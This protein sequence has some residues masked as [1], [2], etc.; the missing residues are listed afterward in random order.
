MIII[1]IATAQYIAFKDMF[2]G[3]DGKADIAMG[4]AVIG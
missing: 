2:I 1:K 3:V 4:T